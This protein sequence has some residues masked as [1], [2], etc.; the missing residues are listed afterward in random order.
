[1]VYAAEEE[2]RG[3]MMGLWVHLGHMS[4]S[5][6]GLYSL[7][8]VFTDVQ[9][10]VDIVEYSYI[11]FITRVGVLGACEASVYVGHTGR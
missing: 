5:V 8:A 11:V 3:R 6:M 7:L 4:K 9:P 1:M 10:G 2:R